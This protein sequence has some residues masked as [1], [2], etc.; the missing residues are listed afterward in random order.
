MKWLLSIQMLILTAKETTKLIVIDWVTSIFLLGDI[1]TVNQHHLHQN[2]H[3][4]GEEPPWRLPPEGD[5]SEETTR[6]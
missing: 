1:P 5:H 6:H 3:P 2:Q 4:H